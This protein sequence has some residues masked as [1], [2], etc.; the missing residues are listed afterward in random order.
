MDA[1]S[2][3]GGYALF[4]IAFGGWPVFLFLVFHR[5]RYG[6]GIVV[7][8]SISTFFIGSIIATLGTTSAVRSPLPF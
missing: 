2:S 4:A 1:L 6:V 5:H 7:A 8:L 3:L